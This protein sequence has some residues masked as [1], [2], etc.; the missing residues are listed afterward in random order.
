[1]EALGG[2]IIGSPW[3]PYKALEFIRFKIGLVSLLRALKGPQW[4]YKDSEGPYGLYEAPKG[5][6][7]P[8]RA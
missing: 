2:L 8:P 3:R 7:R 4:A 6:L 1:M 5:L